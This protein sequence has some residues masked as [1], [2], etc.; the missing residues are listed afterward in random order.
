MNS[1][2]TRW[3]VQMPTDCTDNEIE[4]MES[5]IRV[6]TRLNKEPLILLIENTITTEENIEN[7]FYA[8]WERIDLFSIACTY[9]GYGQARIMSQV[10]TLP[11]NYSEL[12]EFDVLI[13]KIINIERKKYVINQNDLSQLEAALK[14]RYADALICV[15]AALQ[16]PSIEEKSILMHSGC[17]AMAE[18]SGV[19][20]VKQRCPSCGALNNTG[21]PATNN[22]IKK[23]FINIIGKDKGKDIYKKFSILRQKIG[24]GKP[25]RTLDEHMEAK[26]DI[27]FSQG[28]VTHQLDNLIGFA[29]N[30]GQQ[31]ITGQPFAI[32][33]F[34]RKE[35]LINIKFKS[36]SG[37]VAYSKVSESESYPQEWHELE[38]AARLDYQNI[39]NEETMSLIFGT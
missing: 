31:T 25:L 26:F 20:T 28:A 39:F 37:E 2:N 35:D 16:N 14:G 12:A 33:K 11:S 1:Y 36:F 6:V 15:A 3:I 7:A 27:A 9:I 30:A 21:R 17:Q 38:I 5:K 10:A 8:S 4:F 22:Y 34:S 32:Y 23:F 18:T 13:Q 19:D 29:R 24:H